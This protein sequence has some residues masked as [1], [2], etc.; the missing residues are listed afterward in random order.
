M[1]RLVEL[2]IEVKY[3]GKERVYTVTEASRKFG[4]LSATIYKRLRDG[5]T[6]RQAVGLDKKPR[7]PGSGITCQKYYNG[8]SYGAWALK[9]GVSPSAI[10]KRLAR[11]MPLDEVF[12]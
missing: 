12:K 8:L 9:L 1:G 5:A 11:G 7:K 3:R 4:V 2:L 10:S 6:H